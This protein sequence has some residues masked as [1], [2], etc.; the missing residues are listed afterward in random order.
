MRFNTLALLV[1][2]TLAGTVCAQS[3]KSQYIKEQNDHEPPVAT[4]EAPTET[5]KVGISACALRRAHHSGHSESAECCRRRERADIKI[6][7]RDL[8]AI[9]TSDA[10][11]KSWLK[12]QRQLM[13]EDEQFDFAMMQATL[14]RR[15]R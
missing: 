8:A 15:R 12:N 10:Q 1:S 4:C 11:L 2:F 6:M 9:N 13:K 5:Y 3:S 7:R 14:G